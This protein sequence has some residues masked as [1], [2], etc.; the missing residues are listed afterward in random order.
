MNQLSSP[1]LQQAG[2]LPHTWPAV[3]VPYLQPE[4]GV[5]RGLGVGEG[6]A[7]LHGTGTILGPTQV[8]HMSPLTPP[9]GVPGRKGNEVMASTSPEASGEKVTPEGQSSGKP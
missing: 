4:A 6:E 8:H 1:Q 5:T 2:N 7:Q 3:T 9:Q